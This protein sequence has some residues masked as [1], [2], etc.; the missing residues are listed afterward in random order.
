[1]SNHELVRVERE[2]RDGGPIA[3]LIL[4]RPGK[5]NAMSRQM[6]RELREAAR[7]LS[8]DRDLRAVVLQA[9]GDRA[10]VGGADIGE[11]SQMDGPSAREFITNLHLAIDEVRRM[12]VPVIG[13]IHGYCLGAGLE[14]VAAC[15]FRVASDN[16]KFGMPEVRV[17]LPSVIEAVLL[18]HVMGWGKAAEILLTGDM[19]DAEDAR[20]CGLVQ[21]VTTK[22]RLDEQVDAWLGSIL[23]SGPKAVR[24]QKK[25][26]RAWE[27]MPIDAAIR[28]AIDAFEEANRGPEPREYLSKALR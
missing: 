17:G 9:A 16:A 28:A 10:F 18:P 12:P 13:R 20:L 23:A 15:D 4:N 26:I 8:Q 22:D 7:E 14:L 24:Q 21:K 27:N 3:R 1:M 25:L 19:I 5:L 11:M 2:A 6:N